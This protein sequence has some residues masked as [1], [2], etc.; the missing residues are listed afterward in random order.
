MAAGRRGERLLRRTVPVRQRSGPISVLSPGRPNLHYVP[1]ENYRCTVTMLSG[2]PGGG[3]DTWVAANLPDVPVVSLDDLRD[4]LGVDAG[5]NQGEVIQE[6]QERVGSTCGR[7]VRSAFNA[8]NLLRQTR[9]RW[10]DLF[11][12]Y[13]A[14]IEIVY[15]EPPFSVII[16]RNKQREKSVPETV[17]RELADKCEPPTGQRRINW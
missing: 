9:Q 7:V 2:L 13:H 17:I 4:E 1:H 8:T 16:A 11:A 5:D 3:K 6:A 10:I 15:I 14:R 12:D